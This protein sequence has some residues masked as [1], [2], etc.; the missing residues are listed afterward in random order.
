MN[1]LSI[2]GRQRRGRSRGWGVPGAGVG[3][4]GGP[5][6]APT[7]LPAAAQRWLILPAFLA[8]LV[9]WGCAGVRRESAGPATTGTVV[10]QLTSLAGMAGDE[11]DARIYVDGR[12]VGNYQAADTALA[13]PTGEHTVRLAVPRVYESR[14]L[15]N[16]DTAMV[17]YSLKGEERIEVLGGGARQSLVFN[18]DNLKAREIKDD[19]GR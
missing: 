13:L 5:T 11:R 17:P 3:A 15:P 8:A 6:D 1:K 14:K 10:V 4:V 12:F 7:G 19:D 18:S 16:G 2:E 9:S